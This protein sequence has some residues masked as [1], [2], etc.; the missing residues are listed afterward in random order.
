MREAHQVR[1][2]RSYTMAWQMAIAQDEAIPQQ[3][4]AQWTCPSK[5]LHSQL[6][7]QQQCSPW[8]I[9]S[10]LK[11]LTSSVS[12][13]RIIEYIMLSFYRLRLTFCDKHVYSTHMVAYKN[14]HVVF[15]FWYAT[16]PSEFLYLAAL[17]ET[18]YFWNIITNVALQ[19]SCQISIFCG[20]AE[21]LPYY[22]L[23]YHNK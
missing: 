15:P 18:C 20:I 11:T 9:L 4:M 14:L 12:W 22:I 3:N 10:F 19:K 8:V 21:D 16:N 17:Q 2:A 23:K 5:T 1:E 13:P 6:S 7:K